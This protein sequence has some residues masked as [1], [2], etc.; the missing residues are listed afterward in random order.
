MDSKEQ[1]RYDQAVALFNDGGW[2]YEARTAT[3]EEVTDLAGTASPSVM[4]RFFTE[5]PGANGFVSRPKTNNGGLRWLKGWLQ[6]NDP[7]PQEPEP[8]PETVEIV[9]PV[10]EPTFEVAE[11]HGGQNPIRWNVILGTTAHECH[12]Q[13]AYTCLL[14]VPQVFHL[15]E[16][17]SLRDQKIVGLAPPNIDNRDRNRYGNYA[18]IPIR[19]TANVG[20]NLQLANNHNGRF[21]V[22]HYHEEF[23]E[24]K[25]NPAFEYDYESGS[26]P[27][28]YELEFLAT[29]NNGHTDTRKAVV[30]VQDVEESVEIPGATRLRKNYW[31]YDETLE[32][33]VGAAWG[34]AINP[35][36]PDRD[37]RGYVCEM[38]RPSG[39]FYVHDSYKEP[40]VIKP[41]P[42]AT[43]TPGQ[44]YTVKAMVREIIS[45]GKYGSPQYLEANILITN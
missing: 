40:C 3:R 27:N 26:H 28:R 24:L 39:H 35:W 34:K 36:D 20:I 45:T 42:W 44:T 29:D 16:Q 4:P 11:H 23:W 22:S 33:P 17:T 25:I 19:T 41:K 12:T 10:P 6:N 5:D 8:T 32:M 1:G 43:H 30:L 38:M 15:Y 14:Q 13:F 7:A 31:K 2:A 9:T 18:Y 21:S 37:A